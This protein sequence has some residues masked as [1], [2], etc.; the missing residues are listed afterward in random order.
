MS[1][2]DKAVILV[3]NYSN[4]SGGNLVA[5]YNKKGRDSNFGAPTFSLIFAKVI[6]DQG[7]SESSN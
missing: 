2:R 5:A 1:I 3:Q 6:W 7:L 4:F